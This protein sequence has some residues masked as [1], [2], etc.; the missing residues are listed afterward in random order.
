MGLGKA[1][2]LADHQNLA[3]LV[4]NLHH[5][6][7]VGKGDGHGLFAEDVLA[8]LE[9]IDGQLRV[10]VVGSTDGDRVDF[11]IGKQLFRA[12]VGLAAVFGRHVLG[13]GFCGVEET[14]Q[15]AVGVIR[16]LGNVTNLGDLAA[17]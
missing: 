16:I 15:L 1:L 14:H 9:G 3:L 8:C 5:L 6:L 2:V 11:G 4:G 17:A 13:A 7:A 10:G 12:V